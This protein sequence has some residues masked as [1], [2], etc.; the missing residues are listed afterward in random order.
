MEQKKKPNP[1]RH[2]NREII[3]VSGVE[4]FRM[5]RSD[6]FSIQFSWA[7]VSRQVVKP[8]SGMINR[9]SERFFF[10]GGH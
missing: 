4:Y 10:G 2:P 1:K 6:Q 5:I 3:R 9:I 7:L 8:S